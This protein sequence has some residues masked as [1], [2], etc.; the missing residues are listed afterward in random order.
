M[1]FNENSEAIKKRFMR[2]VEL[3]ENLDDCWIWKGGVVTSGY[4]GFHVNGKSHKAHRVSFELF[5]KE[6]PKGLLV[7]HAC[8][9][10]LC[11]NPAHLF[12]GTN[13]EN[14]ADMIKKNRQAKGA[15]NGRAKL[16]WE[17]V[18]EIRHLRSTGLSYKELSKKFHVTGGNIWNILSHRTWK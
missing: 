7:C 14:T 8:D 17:D 10:K 5:V 2:L 12:L 1:K 3:P 13:K 4:G 9:I 16:S 15:D 18:K 6:V 11:V